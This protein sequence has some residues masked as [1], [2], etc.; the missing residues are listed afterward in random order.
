MPYWDEP[1]VQWDDPLVNWDDPRTYQE[2]LN[3]NQP[4][5]MFDVALDINRLSIPALIARIRSIVSGVKG[6]AALAAL[7]AEADALGATADTLENCETALTS[8]KSA[9]TQK[10]VERDAAEEPVFAK[11]KALAIN[12]GKTAPDEATVLAANLRVAGK[13]G[14]RPVPDKP[15]GLELTVGDEEG[16]ISGQCNGQPGIVDYHE[17]EFTT[18]DPNASGTVWQHADTS[19]KSVFELKNL[20]SGQKVWVRLRAVNARGK[21]PWSDPACVRVP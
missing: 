10:V 4:H 9:V 1:G 5:A 13:P 3:S 17:I 12:V 2:I 15:T 21:S 6:Q 16:E 19:K 18:G 20:P 11:A 14:P 8:A 7:H